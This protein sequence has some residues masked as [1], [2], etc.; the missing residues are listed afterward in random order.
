MVPKSTLRRRS[1]AQR[2]NRATRRCRLLR[3]Q[4]IWLIDRDPRTTISS[5]GH[6][7]YQLSRHCDVFDDSRI[8]V[9]GMQTPRCSSA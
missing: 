8:D 9:E 2:I 5:G 3:S 1:S 4:L 7:S 6:S